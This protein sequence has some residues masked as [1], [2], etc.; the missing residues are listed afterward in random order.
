MLQGTAQAT[1]LAKQLRGE[2]SLPE[3]M[4]WTAL[5]SRPGGLKFRKQ[6]PSGPYVADF[7]CH[8]AR[9]VV[10]VDG[11]THGCGDRPARDAA[12][13]GWFRRRGLDVMRISA[14][15]VLRDCDAVMRGIVERAAQRLDDER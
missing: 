10:E 15:E 5:R 3:V 2:M 4:L 6:H 13:D 1:L 11:G 14:S 7:Y 8:A 12:R 9:L